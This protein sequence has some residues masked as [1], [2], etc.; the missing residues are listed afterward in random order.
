MTELQKIMDWLMRSCEAGEHESR[1][2]TRRDGKTSTGQPDKLSIL[3]RLPHDEK[4][5]FCLFP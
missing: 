4:V 1:S 5:F 2:E 3:A